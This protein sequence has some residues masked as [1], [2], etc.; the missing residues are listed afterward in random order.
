[1][2]LPLVCVLLS[3]VLLPPTTFAASVS[4]LR[5][6]VSSSLLV[7]PSSKGPTLL[8]PYPAGSP[9]A[10][11]FFV[12]QWNNPSPFSSDNT[13]TP[14]G[15]CTPPRGGSV[16]VAVGSPSLRACVLRAQDGARTV[17][18]AATGASPEAPV[19]CGKEFDAF[20]APVGAGRTTVEGRTPISPNFLPLADSP[21]LSTLASVRAS[22]TAALLEAETQPRCGPRGSCGP[23][24]S[25]DWV[26]SVLGIVLS[27]RE[28]AIDSEDALAHATA[29][30]ETLFFQIILSDTRAGPTCNATLDPC[31][32]RA[33]H[34][35]AS[36]S[37]T[38]GCSDAVGTLQPGAC[39]VAG[40]PARAFDLDLLSRITAAISE[41]AASFGAD[42][43]FSHWRVSSAYVGSGLQGSATFTTQIAGWDLRYTLLGAAA[44][45][46]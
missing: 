46:M 25:I 33:L 26:Y 4:Y 41:A 14:F 29:R 38:F 34:W 45:S 12:A 18:L 32:P 21:P 22:F 6:P 36:A 11:G 23:S 9:N 43:D 13:S 19:D 3:I 39:L 1:M 31:L 40:G 24:G 28:P 37:P 42:G 8:G 17:E 44:A 16:E 7:D 27:N 10:S 15:R 2:S 20:L 35:F 5:Q 30:D